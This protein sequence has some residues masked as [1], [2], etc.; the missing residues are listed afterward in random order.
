MT[1]FNVAGKIYVSVFKE[2]E[3]V[4]SSKAININYYVNGGWIAEKKIRDIKMFHLDNLEMS[5]LNL[6]EK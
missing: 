5:D 4:A 6:K 3:N 1:S 2:T